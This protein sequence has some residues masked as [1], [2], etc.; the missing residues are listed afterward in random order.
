MSEPRKRHRFR[1][2]RLLGV[3]AVAFAAA[4]V[5]AW[6]F[7]GFNFGYQFP[8][9]DTIASMEAALHGPKSGK[10]VVPSEYYGPILSQLTPSKKDSAPAKWVVLGDLDIRTKDGQSIYVGLYDLGKSRCAFSAGPTFESRAYYMV[11]VGHSDR[12]RV[13]MEDAMDAA[14]SQ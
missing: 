6:Y 1:K 11:I 9:P 10:F 8:S 13:V 14:E 2:R 4:V 5:A 12:L 3:L 7:T